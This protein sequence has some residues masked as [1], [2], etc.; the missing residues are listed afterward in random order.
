MSVEVPEWVQWLMPIV[1]GESRPEGDEEAL[2]RTSEAYRAAADGIEAVRADGDRAA[3]MAKSAMGTRENWGGS[4]PTDA[5]RSGL[6]SGAER[7]TVGT[8]PN[9]ERCTVEIHGRPD[10]VHFGGE[11]FSAAELVHILCSAPG[12]SAGEPV[13]LLLRATRMPAATG[14]G[15][16]PTPRGRPS[17]AGTSRASGSAPAPTETG[18]STTA[19]PSGQRYPAW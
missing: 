4:K 9:P 10:G 13:R 14:R 8:A 6:V 17:P 11:P 5:V 15:S 7:Q 12:Y 16:T 2:R 3:E 19:P 1:V 18:P